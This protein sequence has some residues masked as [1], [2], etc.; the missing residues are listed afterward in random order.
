[1]SEPRWIGQKDKY[2]CGAIG[3]ANVLKWAGIGFNWGEE[4]NDLKKL[5]RTTIERG[6]SLNNLERVL[7]TY[8]GLTVRRRR[9]WKIAEVIDHVESRGCV[10]FDFTPPLGHNMR[11][12]PIERTGHYTTLVDVMGE[13]GNIWF[14]FI[15]LQEGETISWIDRKRFIW[16]F[17]HRRWDDC[18][19][20]IRMRG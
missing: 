10:I 19:F 6:T 9:R 12:P 18:A 2:S 16:L 3:I 1:M 4:N 8:G 15:N 17:S 13:R 7:R 14:K 5:C 11:L 20:F